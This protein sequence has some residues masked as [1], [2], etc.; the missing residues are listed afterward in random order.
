MASRRSVSVRIRGKEYRIRSEDDEQTLQRVAGYLD[1]TLS[2]V[3]SRTGTVDSLDVALLTALN[4]ARELVA[5][6]EGR[7][8]VE[9]GGGMGVDVDRLRSLIELAESG[10]ESPSPSAH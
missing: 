7:R 2:K 8:P 1:E 3:E 10:L 5:I 6:R 4:L 9:G